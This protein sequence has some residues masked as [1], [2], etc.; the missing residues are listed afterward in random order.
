MLKGSGTRKLGGRDSLRAF[1]R[2]LGWSLVALFVSLFPSRAHAYTWMIKH[3]YA[4]CPVCHADPSGGELLTAYGRVQ[5]DELLRMRY[6]KSSESSHNEQKAPRLARKTVE[7]KTDALSGADEEAKPEESAAEEEESATTATE[8]EE[9][10]AATTSSEDSSYAGEFLW[11]LVKTPDWLLLGGSYRHMNVIRPSSDA[12]KFSTFPM[13]ADLYGQLQFGNFR[14]EGS[15]GVVRV[16]VGSP[17]ARAAQLTTNQG[18]Q[19]NLL[20]RTHW[21]GYDLADGTMTIRAGHMNLPF[22]IRIPE[23][24]MW[25]RQA[26]LT[27]RE[28]AQQ[29]GVAFAYNG[30]K[31]RGEIMGIVGNYQVNPDK[32]RQRGYS[33]Y[34]EYLVGERT[35]VGV[36]SMVTK[37][38]KDRITLEPNPLRQ[39]HGAYV[40]SALTDELVL[41]A[42]ADALLTS[43]HDTGYV[44]FAQADFEIIR[45]LHLMATG[46][47]QDRGYDRLIGGPKTK[48]NGQPQFGVWGSVDWFFL[49]HC[50]LRTDVYSR[51]QDQFTILAQVHVFL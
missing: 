34:G 16:G 32:Y 44:G 33:L 50:E 21:L 11:G 17:Y 20:S 23:H 36:S 30:E 24:T 18:D 4:S 2:F 43:D 10:P 42:E 6:G 15:L 13:M 39:A 25:V 31:L 47:V 48:S 3:G 8:E 46:E 41:L 40:R 27:D 49:P 5:S 29:D 22:G 14:A 45:G 51:Q 38:S 12:K 1:Q 19:W 9:A 26:T 37:A 28:S 7:S 35:A